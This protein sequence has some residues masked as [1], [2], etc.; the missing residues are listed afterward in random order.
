MDY[1]KW[2]ALV[3]KTQTEPIAVVCSVEV[4]S[5]CVRVRVCWAKIPRTDVYCGTCLFGTLL[6]FKISA[7]ELHVKSSVNTHFYSE[8]LKCKISAKSPSLD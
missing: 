5:V 3:T 1:V 4:Y 7:S 8:F 2:S 6:Q